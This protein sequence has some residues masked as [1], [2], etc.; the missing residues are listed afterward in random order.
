MEISDVP[1]SKLKNVSNFTT[2]IID[3]SPFLS[4]KYPLLDSLSI[5]TSG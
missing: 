2:T 1:N 5:E 4:S 3:N